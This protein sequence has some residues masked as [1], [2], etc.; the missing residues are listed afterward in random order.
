MIVKIFKSIPKGVL[1]APS[2]KSYSHRYLIA[3]GLSN[4]ESSVSNLYFSNDVLASLNCLSSFGC[5]YNV[6]ENSV[7]F[8]N[9]ENKNPQVFECN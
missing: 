8:K 6:Y 2:S 9:N 3:A 1:N 4:N 5:D 7:T